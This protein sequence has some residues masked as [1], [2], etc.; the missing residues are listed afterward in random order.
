MAPDHLTKMAIQHTLHCL[1]GCS[2]GEI[3]G[4]TI[5]TLL[6]WEVF[7][8]VLFSIPLAFFFGFL[9]ASWSIVR[10]GKSWREAIGA[11]AGTE[12]ASITS[13]EVVDSAF[14]LLIPGAMSAYI[15]DPLYW[16]KLLASLAVA[17]VITVPVNRYLI[18][19]NPH[20][21]HHHH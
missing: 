8:K 13:M 12:T 5:T 4:M 2:I 18:S 10:S 7:A 3:T 1:L 15:G 14:L 6:G 20:A 19:R 17:F 9:L 16:L 11:A 21:Y